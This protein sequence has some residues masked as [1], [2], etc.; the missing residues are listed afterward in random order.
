M[1]R[2]LKRLLDE[3]GCGFVRVEPAGSSLSNWH[4]YPRASILDANIGDVCLNSGLAE[5]NTSDPLPH[6]PFPPT[7]GLLFTP[8]MAQTPHAV[9]WC[10]GTPLCLTPAL[11]LVTF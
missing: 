11:L 10:F 5:V 6:P 7:K 3:L 9:V 2:H 4:V 8:G 1:T